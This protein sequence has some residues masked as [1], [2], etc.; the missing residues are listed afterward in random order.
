MFTRFAEDTYRHYRE[1]A[2]QIRAWLKN[3]ETTEAEER[4]VRS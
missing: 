1:H 3:M 4:G 2:A